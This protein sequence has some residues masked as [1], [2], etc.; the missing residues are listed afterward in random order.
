MAYADR[1]PCPVIG[2]RAS[3][4]DYTQ[5]ELV[6]LFRWLLDDGIFWTGNLRLGQAVRELGFQK[7]GPRIRS[8]L[9]AALDLAYQNPSGGLSV[10]PRFDSM[11]LE[12]LALVI[13]DV[14]GPY[15]R[16]GWQLEALLER[17]GWSDPP[18][19]D[20]SPWVTWLT[21]MLIDR[22]ASGGGDLR[23]VWCAG[24]VIRSNT[25]TVPTPPRPSG[26]PSIRSCGPSGWS[27][28]IRQ[29]DRYSVSWRVTADRRPTWRRPT[30]SAGS[31][32]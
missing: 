31:R 5:A 16:A 8:N 27:S 30:W 25:R 22:R 6:R 4:T 32:S 28:R 26:R 15:E 21:E 2:G 3:I 7:L 23:T 11:T 17:A 29:A 19:Y 9:T 14:D 18:M 20:N 10:M 12:R 13:C 24:S 1:G